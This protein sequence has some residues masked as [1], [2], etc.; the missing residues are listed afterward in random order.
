MLLPIAGTSP[1][2]NAP[3][4]NDLLRHLPAEEWERLRSHARQVTLGHAEL[5]FANG[6]PATVTYFPQTCIISMIAE[7][8]NGDECEYGCIGREGMLGLQIALG[9]QPLEGR[10]LCQL[11]GTALRIEGSVLKGLTANGEMPQLQRLL[12]RYAQ[13][14]INVLAQSAACNALHT[15]TQR[16]ARWLLSSGD[17]AGSERFELTQDFLSRM[18]GAR[19]ASVTKAASALQDMHAIAYSRGRIRITDRAILESEACECYLLMR[20]QFE[21]VFA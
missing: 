16:T 4:V 5:I 2:E 8:K 12:L 11:E 17:R 15:L 10:A 14:T 20:T 1:R 21:T 9:A 13:A 18:L 19:R 7:M 3:L 6:D